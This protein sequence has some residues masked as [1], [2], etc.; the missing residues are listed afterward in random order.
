M[1]KT[2]AILL[3]CAFAFGGLTATGCGDPCE[4]AVTKM[5]ECAGKADKTVGEKMGKEKSKTIEACKKN[6]AQKKRA[7][8]CSKESDCK[9][10]VEC[11]SK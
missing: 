4:K 10:F 5:I 2:I 8:E 6:D 9:K 3:T 1:K 7:K 11:M